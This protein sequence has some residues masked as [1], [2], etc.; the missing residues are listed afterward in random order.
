MSDDLVPQEN[1]GHELRFGGF[2]DLC[3]MLIVL[4]DVHVMPSRTGE[5]QHVSERN[6]GA[7]F[8]A[9]P[10][11]LGSQLPAVVIEVQPS[12]EAAKGV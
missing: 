4:N 7:L 12:T 9:P 10:G 2:D 1:V 11:R 5:H 6:G 3:E 8:P